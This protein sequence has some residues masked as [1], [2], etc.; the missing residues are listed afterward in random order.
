M[1]VILDILS[2]IF[3]VAVQGKS[4]MWADNNFDKSI[5]F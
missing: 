2:M 4:E 5:Y 1:L 3:R